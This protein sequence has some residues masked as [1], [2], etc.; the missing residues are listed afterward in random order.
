MKFFADTAN[1]DEIEELQEAGLIDGVTTNPSLVLKSK[2]P[3]KELVEAICR[4]TDGPVSAEV[5]STDFN[6]MMREGRILGAIADNVV[7]K[8]PLTL[9]GLR[10]CRHFR[11]D[12]FQTNVTLCFSANQALMAAKAGAT[13]VSP[14]IGRLDDTNIDGMAVIRDIRRILDNYELETQILAA[15]VRTPNHVREAALIG[16]DAATMPTSTLRALIKHP[17]TDKGLDDFVTD[18]AKTGQSIG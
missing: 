7:V 8:L 6:G 10:A 5:A 4:V 15:S 13:Y 16:A 11:E 9:D 2:R 14:F 3:I 18:W 17:L 1:L 12:G